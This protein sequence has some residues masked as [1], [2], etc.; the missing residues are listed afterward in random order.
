MSSSHI[1]QQRH[2]ARRTTNIHRNKELAPSHLPHPL[3]SPNLRSP[4][5]ST[6]PLCQGALDKTKLA[7]ASPPALAPLPPPPSLEP[8][9]CTD[10]VS[11]PHAAPDR[12]TPD[13]RQLELLIYNG[14]P[15]HDHW[16]YFVQRDAGSPSVGVKTHATGDVRSGFAFEIKRAVDLESRE[17]APSRRIPLQW[18][19]AVHFDEV[20]WND[21]VYKVDAQPACG[22]E[23]E[24]SRVKVPGKTLRSAEEVRLLLKLCILLSYVAVLKER[25][26]LIIHRATAARLLNETARPGSSSRQTTSQIGGY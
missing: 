24:L 10:P 22:L 26:Q 6:A 25:A 14:A 21:G 19:D 23:T 7:M 8:K 9:V 16:A 2:I 4:I 1:R 13:A 17:E 5:I 15:F 11:P 20:M 12:P 3:D 18:L